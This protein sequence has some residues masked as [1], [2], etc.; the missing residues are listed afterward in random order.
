MRKLNFKYIVAT[1]ALGFFAS[2]EPENATTDARVVKPVVTAAVTTYTIAEG[3]TAT[4][5]LTVDTR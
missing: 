2:C 3:A 1:A 5:N 4:V